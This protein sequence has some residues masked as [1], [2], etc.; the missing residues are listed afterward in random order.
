MIE[1]Y[2]IIEINQLLKNFYFLI[3][4]DK[5][6]ISNVLFLIFFYDLLIKIHLNENSVQELAF[7]ISNA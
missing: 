3:F 6:M 2:N 5:T 4:V 7:E 1:F